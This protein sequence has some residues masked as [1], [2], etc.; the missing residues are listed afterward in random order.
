MVKW[1]I[2]IL[3]VVL[4]AVL[5]I[6]YIGILKTERIA[7]TAESDDIVYSVR[8]VVINDSIL[9]DMRSEDRYKQLRSIP[10]LEENNAIGL[11]EELTH[12]DTPAVINEAI[13]A[14]AR[15]NSVESVPVLLDVYEENRV[16]EDGY[17]ESIRLQVIDALGDIG[18]S[19]SVNFL[20]NEFKQDESLIYHEH[21]LDALIKINS[22]DSLPAL[23]G[24][25]ENLENNP[26]PDDWIELRFQ[27][28]R[29]KDKVRS[30]INEINE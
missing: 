27:W 24:Y 18:S 28:N 26:P 21:I 23:Q 13:G 12:D 29:I 20:S 1:L 17:G 25:L 7:K 5:G 4:L 30:A 15:L 3:I 2:S 22:K 11:I 8:P 19:T 9:R 10:Y 16:R 6:V 14:L